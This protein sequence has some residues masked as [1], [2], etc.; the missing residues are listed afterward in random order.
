M[1][2]ATELVAS[3]VP[4]IQLPQRLVQKN[5]GILGHDA[6]DQQI[7]LEKDK[8]QGLKL[9]REFIQ[10]TEYS[11]TKLSLLN[12]LLDAISIPP[13]EEGVNLRRPEAI[14]CFLSKLIGHGTKKTSN[15]K[16]LSPSESKELNSPAIK[17]DKFFFQQFLNSF[18]AYAE[19]KKTF[20]IREALIALQGIGGSVLQWDLARGKFFVLDSQNVS[21]PIKE[22]LQKIGDIAGTFVKIVDFLTQAKGE[23]LILKKFLQ[24]VASVRQE[25][26]DQIDQIM[27]QLVTGTYKGTVFSLLTWVSSEW[28][29]KFD[30]FLKAFTVERTKSFANSLYRE[31]LL[32]DCPWTKQCFSFSC[33][34]YFEHLLIGTWVSRGHLEHYSFFIVKSHNVKEDDFWASCYTLEASK[35]PDFIDQSLAEKILLIG[36]CRAFMRESMH[37]SVQHKNE[38]LDF[39]AIDHY[40]IAVQFTSYIN[41]LHSSINQQLFDAY[42]SRYATFEHFKGLRSTLLMQRGDFATILINSLWNVLD[43]KSNS[44]FRHSL[45]AILDD[46]VKIS[47]FN[48]TV[49]ERV[50]I[51]LFE[52]FEGDIGWD[53]FCLEYRSKEFAESIVFS[54]RIMSQYHKMF[55]LLLKAHRARLTLVRIY[56]SKPKCRLSHRKVHHFIERLIWYFQNCIVTPRFERF[57]KSLNDN[58]SFEALIEG[59]QQ[60]VE[61]MVKEMFFEAVD[62]LI[63]QGYWKVIDLVCKEADYN[64]IESAIAG[65]IEKA[66]MYLQCVG[67]VSCVDFKACC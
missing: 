63:Y 40:W 21:T 7:L 44:I 53:F 29:D 61:G 3:L 5:I 58:R 1:L 13:C 33:K 55:A 31:V 22:I 2:T 16:A 17:S 27:Q 11:S 26:L 24:F 48:P 60:L 19:G 12:V 34:E 64:V 6:A 43:K 42:V 41:D 51:R 30:F 52:T 18:S 50:D 37:I 35:R 14:L 8:I 45:L 23:D 59:H 25:Y 15:E 39:D 36:K 28:K 9:K 46:T 65:V 62:P 47:N 66:S 57:I 56:E 10:S 49:Q 20:F 54:P 4:K 32:W 67:F 38:I